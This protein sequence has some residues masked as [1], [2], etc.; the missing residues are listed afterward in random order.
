M[1]ACTK[2]V[3]RL[4]VERV[5]F[6]PQECSLYQKDK[7]FFLDKVFFHFI[8]CGVNITLSYLRT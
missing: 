4:E 6:K 2:I 5:Q 3:E 8:K 1:R 7:V